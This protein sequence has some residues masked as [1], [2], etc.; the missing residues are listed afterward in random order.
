M[1][2]LRRQQAAG[3]SAGRP[4]GRQ[5]NCTQQ[6]A[7]WHLTSITSSVAD[8]LP[9]LRAHFSWHNLAQVAW[10]GSIGCLAVVALEAGALVGLSACG[11]CPGGSSPERNGRHSG[12]SRPPRG[13]LGRGRV[14]LAGPT[15]CWPTSHSEPPRSHSRRVARSHWDLR[16]LPVGASPGPTGRASGTCKARLEKRVGARRERLGRPTGTQSSIREATATLG[17]GSKEIT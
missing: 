8:D 6:R 17:V 5:V 7:G 4:R 2:G 1:G 15:R 14:P 13:R 11:V 9:L 12:S 16:A 10:E 3:T